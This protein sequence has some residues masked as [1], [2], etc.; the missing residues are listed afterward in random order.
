MTVPSNANTSGLEVVAWRKNIWVAEGIG[1]GWML[2][3]EQPEP[4]HQPTDIEPLVTAAS[5]QARI[6]EL[7]EAGRLLAAKAEHAINE[8]FQHIARATAAEARADRLAKFGQHTNWE[9]S[10]GYPDGEEEDGCW[11]VHSVN[12]GRS[13][14]EW[15]LIGRGETPDDAIRAA[16][17]QETQ[18]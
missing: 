9:L 6:A 18:P 1:T 11:L 3:N 10:H 4:S 12:G 16:L 8:G 2:S 7:E 14:R 17:Q 5:A 13:D 15:T